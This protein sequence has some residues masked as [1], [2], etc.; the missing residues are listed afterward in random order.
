ME[1]VP[2]FLE[3]LNRIL[4]KGEAVPLP[5]TGRITF[6]QPMRLQPGE[7]KTQFLLRARTALLM[8]PVC[9][10]PSTAISRAS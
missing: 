10:S 9:T 3:N 1:L 6:G 7:G 2:V 4:P 5:V 8:V